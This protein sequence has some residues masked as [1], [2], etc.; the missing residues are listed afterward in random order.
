[1]SWW[2]WFGPS[3]PTAAPCLVM[4]E[5]NIGAGKT[6]LCRALAR[7]PALVRCE[8]ETLSDAFQ[9]LFY[10]RPERYGFALQMSMCATRHAAARR[11]CAAT[12]ARRAG[13][14]VLDRSVLGD[15]AF[16]AYNYA[17]GH[18]D[19]AEWAVYREAA[20]G[21]VCAALRRATRGAAERVTLL[22]L[23]DTP[24]A[25]LSRAV[26]RGGADAHALTLVYVHGLHVAHEACVALA[27]A[28]CRDA[29]R[30]RVLDFARYG[31]ATRGGAEDVHAAHALLRDVLVE[32]GDDNDDAERLA[33]QALSTLRSRRVRTRLASA[34]GLE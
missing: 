11:D 1:M 25:C 6:S 30:V 31:A 15:Y 16:A 10:A 20:G 28:R 34:L 13:V 27:R 23:R 19:D 7:P 21:D 29:V 4:L 2:S 12:R 3:T 26:Q 32:G 14:T 9:A 22:Y 18:L 8:P 24:E 33:R 17:C 5:G